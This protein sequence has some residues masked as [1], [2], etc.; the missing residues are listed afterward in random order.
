MDFVIRAN[1]MQVIV[2][3]IENYPLTTDRDHRL[4]TYLRSYPPRPIGITLRVR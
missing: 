3:S 1:Q 2:R 4:P